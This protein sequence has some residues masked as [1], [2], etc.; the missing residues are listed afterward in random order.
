M[1]TFNEIQDRHSIFVKEQIPYHSFY[2]AEPPAQSNALLYQLNRA[3]ALNDFPPQFLVRRDSAYPYIALICVT[4]GTGTVLINDTE[5]DMVQGQV[6]L[7]P[8]FTAYE[9]H[10]SAK[11][12]FSIFWV[13]FC[14]GDSERL[15]RYLLEQNGPVFSG[16]PVE[17]L[18]DCCLQ[19]IH[20]PKSHRQIWISRTLNDCLLQLYEACSQEPTAQKEQIC[21]ILDYIDHNLSKNLTLAQMSQMFGY[22]ATYFSKFFYRHTG[23][24]FSHYVLRRRIDG[25]RQLL[26]TTQLPLEQMAKQ[27]GFYVASH[28]VR[29]FQEV[30]GISPSRYRRLH[31]AGTQDDS[32]KK[33]WKSE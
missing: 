21:E 25:A 6:I 33:P 32:S 26:L 10:S 7:L 12:P 22:N 16:E 17:H 20:P 27:L 18:L 8:P 14:G 28:F 9:F 23:T 31:T 11:E 13:E 5:I 15:T 1:S 29:K 4:A 3:G 2:I 24:H 30:E 19:L